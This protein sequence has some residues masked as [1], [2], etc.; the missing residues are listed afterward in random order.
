M[1]MANN[2]L[3]THQFIF[4]WENI[5]QTELLAILENFLWV[6][7]NIIQVT[8]LLAQGLCIK[9]SGFDGLSPIWLLTEAEC[10]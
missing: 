1:K 3:H 9:L 6:K 7:T 5:E 2:I 10:G 4:I 8:P